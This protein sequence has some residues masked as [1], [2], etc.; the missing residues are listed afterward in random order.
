MRLLA[1]LRGA[2]ELVATAEDRMKLILVKGSN[3]VSQ[4]GFCCF[5]RRPD[6]TRQDQRQQYCLAGKILLLLSKTRKNSPGP[7]ATIL[8]RK[9]DFAASAEDPKKFAGTKGSN[10][11]SQAGFCCFCRRPDETRRDQ[12]Q[13][14]CLASRI[15][16]LLPKN[17]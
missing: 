5:R 1:F 8:S 10:I 2:R 15:L 16:L 3:I 11:V 4:A 12:R 9:Q 7:K 14:Y 17:Q 13:Q 6:K